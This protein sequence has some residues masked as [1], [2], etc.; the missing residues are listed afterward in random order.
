MLISTGR[1]QHRPAVAS[2]V[3]PDEAVAVFADYATTRQKA[4]KALAKAFDL[5]LDAPLTMAET[6]PIVRF[7]LDRRAGPT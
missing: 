5:P 1:L 2:V 4:A 6:V 3:A 7:T